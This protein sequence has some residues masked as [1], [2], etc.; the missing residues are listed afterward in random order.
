MLST[1]I[2]VRRGEEIVRASSLGPDDGFAL[3][4]AQPALYAAS[5]K[6]SV[7]TSRAVELSAES[8]TMELQNATG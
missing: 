1:D 7:F 8:L 3:N 2:L 4:S 6:I 5:G